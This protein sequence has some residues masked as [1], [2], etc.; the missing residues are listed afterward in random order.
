MPSIGQQPVLGREN[1]LGFTRSLEK[2]KGLPMRRARN[3]IRDCISVPGILHRLSLIAFARAAALL[4]LPSVRPR[5]HRQTQY[6]SCF[7]GPVAGNNAPLSIVSNQGIRS[8]STGRKANNGFVYTRAPRHEFNVP[9]EDTWDITPVRSRYSSCEH[10]R[11]ALAAAL[12]FR[13]SAPLVPAQ[14]RGPP[15]CATNF[16]LVS[17]QEAQAVFSKVTS[18]LVSTH[19]KEYSSTS[20]LSV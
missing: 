1:R 18:P 6:Y 12:H 4:P 13:E 15:F 2:G 20:A 14:S 5:R 19:W 8:T 7:P 9:D 11:K 10:N 17:S 3:G 16:P